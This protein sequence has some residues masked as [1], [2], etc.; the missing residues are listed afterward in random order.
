[1]PDIS[2]ELQ[3]RLDSVLSPTNWAEAQSRANSWT[4][5]ARDWDAAR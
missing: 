1:L 2:P 4:P 3:A 5:V